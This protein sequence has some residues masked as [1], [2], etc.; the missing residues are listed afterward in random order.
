MSSQ[1][2]QKSELEVDIVND[3]DIVL[4]F[5]EIMQSAA[6]HA[7][8]DKIKDTNK[9]D[10]LYDVVELGKERQLRSVNNNNSKFRTLDLFVEY[11]PKDIYV[12]GGCALTLYDIALRGLK[13]KHGLNALEMRVRRK[14]TDIDLVWFPRVPDVLVGTGHMV[15]SQSPAIKAMVSRL[16]TYLKENKSLYQRKLQGLFHDKLGDRYT[17]DSVDHFEVE[18]THTIEAGVH[19]ITIKCRVNGIALKLCEMSIH[20]SGS[21]QK[22]NEN[23]ERIPF[24][25]PMTEDPAYCPPNELVQVHIHDKV[26]LV[27]NLVL[28]CKQ[29]LF[30]MG[31]KLRSE[32]F[33]TPYEIALDNEKALGSF[34]RVA[35]VL[36]LLESLKQNQRNVS[37]RMNVEN[38]GRTIDE[39]HEMVNYIKSV[40]RK[41]IQSLCSMEMNDEVRMLICGPLKQ[42]KGLPSYLMTSR[43]KAAILKKQHRS[44]S[45]RSLLGLQH[46]IDILIKTIE[47]MKQVSNSGDLFDLLRRT[48]E[49]GSE[50]ISESKKVSEEEFRPPAANHRMIHQRV[51]E[52]SGKV[53]ALYTEYTALV[54]QLQTNSIRNLST[55][56][57]SASAAPFRPSSLSPLVLKDPMSQSMGSMSQSM[58]SMS[59]SMGSLPPLHPYRPTRMGGRSMRKSKHR[60]SKKYNTRKRAKKN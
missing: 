15:T 42:I 32:D 9:Y 54:Q 55:S 34:Y 10:V 20:D 14:T 56:S 26:I 40:F 47:S 52:L 17:I 6:K 59:Q 30:I 27:P 43:S 19:N 46:R 57:L 41:E 48:Y 8:V 53:D 45:Y 25:Q 58:G 50:I 21:S 60:S 13:R 4:Y 3:P 18:H 36:Y 28:Y 39:I 11:R 16:E 22:Y 44:A 31:N 37:E 5:Y 29:Q 35:F 38:V 1:L 23:H 12:Y 49:L 7:A 24:L 33:R 51:E 2:S